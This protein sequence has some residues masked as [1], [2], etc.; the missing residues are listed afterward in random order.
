MALVVA[1]ISIVGFVYWHI[2]SNTSVRVTAHDVE[3]TY[4]KLGRAAPPPQSEIQPTALNR[5]IRLA[6]GNL[7]FSNDQQ[8]GEVADLT[9][10]NLTGAPGLDLVERRSLENVLREL[11]LSLS[12]LVRAREAVRVGK[13]LRAD[14]FL[15]GTEARIGN[16]NSVVVRMVDARTGIL[17]DATVLDAESD[18]RSLAVQLANFV[19]RCRQN[20]ADAMPQRYLAIG[21]FEDVS[22]N[23]RQAS[24]PSQLR[25]YLTTAYQG[26]GVT[27]LE[28]EAADAVF[29]EVRLDLAGLTADS[30]MNAQQ[31]LLSAYWLVDGKFQS[32]EN[33][34]FQ[35]ELILN[36]T[37]MFG[38]M[39]EAKFR[40]VPDES[41]MRQVKGAIDSAMN[42]KGLAALPSRRTEA[43]SQ[44][45]KAKELARSDPEW[46]SSPRFSDF[47]SA[48]E[49]ARRKRNGDEA[50]HAL[51]TA[52][53]LDPTNN[54]AKLYLA[55]GL[56]RYRPER[57]EEARDDWFEILE[58]TPRDR[59]ASQTESDLRWSF[60][61]ANAD[62]EAGK[63]FDFAARR[64]S[65]QTARAYYVQQA[66]DARAR[67]GLQQMDEKSG[68][69]E[70][71]LQFL[72]DS[73]QQTKD[74]WEHKA[75]GCRGALG[76]YDYTR[77][78]GT[79]KIVIAKATAEVL[80]R[81]KEKFPEL[82]PHLTAV[83]LS[84]QSETNGPIMSEFQTYLDTAIAH[85]DQIYNTY[86]FWA[87]ITD[88]VYGWCF[89]HGSYDLVVRLIQ[90]RQR[91]E[92]EHHA[93]RFFDE[94]RI[95]LAYAFMGEQR[96]REALDIFNTYSN[97]PVDVSAKGPWGGLFVPVLT[98]K[99]AAY[100]E[101]KLGIMPGVDPDGFEMESTGIALD[102]DVDIF[103]RASSKL[104]FDAD[105]FWVARGS[106]V[107][108]FGYD[109]KAKSV[110]SLSAERLAYFT[111][112]AIRGD[113]IWLGTAGSGL[114]ELDTASH[115][116][117]QLSEQDGLL[118]DS[119]E[120]L[121]IT[122]DTLWIG[123]ANGLGK[124]DLTSGKIKTVIS[125]LHSGGGNQFAQAPQKLMGL[126]PADSGDIWL[127][128][129]AGFGQLNRYHAKSGSMEAI[130]E[131]GAGSWL[132]FIASSE[133]YVID[134]GIDE[135]KF[136]FRGSSGGDWHSIESGVSGRASAVYLD[137]SNLLVG[138]EGFILVADLVRSKV[139]KHCYLPVNSIDQIWAGGGYV[140]AQYQGKLHSARM[141]NVA[142][143][144]P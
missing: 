46:F 125:A 112:I 118:M 48:D 124:L 133:R 75:S 83:V 35:V 141:D 63:W 132:Q 90:E 119:I 16:S 81:L 58:T 108:R 92:R 134:I 122:G 65:N 136:H 54:E 105:G 104:A 88:H 82:A 5:P 129:G 139:L 1:G 106:T 76:F 10:A 110:E 13:L 56:E 57:I 143:A 126:Q 79:N 38:N 23:N 2:G 20:T 43:R 26:T 144:V 29:D 121:C 85:P 93:D 31:P 142:Q 69:N 14:W 123:Y 138:G 71:G 84:Y 36:I 30:D 27:L 44:L 41:L 12:G 103:N 28:R 66:H 140:W 50:I 68:T 67:A 32:H 70:V 21:A 55:H 60:Y 62:Q 80:P 87:Q 113:R 51:E 24:F 3:A 135:P 49:A 47:P 102:T 9:L 40:G 19:R 64:T 99:E 34:G 78:L 22:V 111:S 53:L 94:E 100:C 137:G 77:A 6:I 18:L 73:V 86:M 37:R 42:D 114:V 7:G 109:L 72:F 91:A 117:R 17:R 33:D 97:R 8:N 61:G 116:S 52:L 15:L 98:G 89:D 95:M 120:Q 101:Q 131:T 25:S 128:V 45:L 115:S 74:F 59:W 39:S 4:A 96:W 107:T 127:L 130:S 11:N